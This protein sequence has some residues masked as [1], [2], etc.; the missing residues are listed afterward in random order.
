MEGA[1]DFEGHLSVFRATRTKQHKTYF[2]AIGR[3]FNTNLEVLKKVN[4]MLDGECKMEPSPRNICSRWKPCYALIMNASTLR[5]VLPQL[6]LTVK[7]K[8]RETIMEFLSLKKSRYGRLTPDVY[9]RQ[10]E[11]F[12]LMKVANK[13]G[14]GLN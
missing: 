2:Q 4:S 10:Q 9:A 13:R 14:K 8:Q 6:D 1:V 3:V 7:R 5:W 12:M 11:L